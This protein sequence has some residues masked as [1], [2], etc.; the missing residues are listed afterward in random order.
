MELQT[1]CQRLAIGTLVI[2]LVALISSFWRE[3]LVLYGM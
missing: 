1:L 3:F 2:S